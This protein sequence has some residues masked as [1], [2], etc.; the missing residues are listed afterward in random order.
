[1]IYLVPN[2][3]LLQIVNLATGFLRL[4]R[5]IENEKGNRF[6]FRMK[7]REEALA[8]NSWN[9]ALKRGVVPFD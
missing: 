2:H 6:P 4:I 9:S 3:L 8:G 1:M 5:E 7:R